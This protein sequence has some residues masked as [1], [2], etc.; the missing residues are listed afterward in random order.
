[1]SLARIAVAR[2]VGTGMLFLS[3]VVLGYISVQR[4]SVDL[5]PS[6]DFP[7]IS[8]TTRYEGVA[9]QEMETL[10]TRPVEQAVSTIEGLERIEA[11]SSEGLSRVSLRFIWGV[12]LDQVLNDVRTMLDRIRN[13]LPEE[14]DAPTVWKFNLSD[15]PVAYLGLSGGGDIRRL[16]YLAEAGKGRG[17]GR[18]PRRAG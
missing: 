15:Y 11:V 12:N 6:V 1:M 18:G 2:P 13:R 16:R 4:L 17:S 14:A 9:P 8:I 5:M 7:R 3:V 10:I